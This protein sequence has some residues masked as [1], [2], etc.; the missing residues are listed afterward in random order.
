MAV[1]VSEAAQGHSD[2][3]GDGDTDDF[4]LFVCDASAHRVTNTG[5]A[6]G[7]SSFA[8]SGPLVAIRVP[9]RFQGGTDLNGDGDVDDL[10]MHVYDTRTGV[11]RNLGLAATGF[12]IVMVG[13]RVVFPADESSQGVDFNGDGDTLDADT[14]VYDA[15]TGTLT[16]FGFDTELFP[17]ATADLVVVAVNESRSGN[18]DLNGDGDMLDDVLFAL[19]LA[20]GEVINVGYAVY[21]SSFRANG[22]IVAFAVSE[23]GQGGVD[24]NGDGDVGDVVLHVFDATTGTVTNAALDCGGADFAFGDH[25]FAWTV[26]E[27]WQGNADLNGD[28]DVSDNVVHVFDTVM[29]TITNL[30]VAN[31][32]FG[33]AASGDWLAFAVNEGEQGGADLN[34]DGDAIDGV[35]FIYDHLTGLATNLGIALR[36]R[37]LL[38]SFGISGSLVAFRVSETG[39][40]NHDLNGDGDTGDRV[41]HVYDAAS[42]TLTN[43][44]VAGLHE[45]LMGA[46]V[47]AFEVSEVRQG[48]HDLNRN[49]RADDPSVLFVATQTHDAPCSAGTVNSSAGPPTAVLRVNGM[50]DSAVS[51]PGSPIQVSFSTSPAGPASAR[52]ALW[53][54]RGGYRLNIGLIIGSDHLGC[55][56]NPSPLQPGLFPQPA[57]CMSGGL[58]LGRTCGDAR[59]LASPQRAP[60][61]ITVAHGIPVSGVFSLQGIVQDNGSTTAL[62]FSVTNA[63]Q[64]IIQ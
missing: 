45:P 4:V 35:I 58:P 50:Q 1:L 53:A 2:L 61:V 32:Q 6:G 26:C 21:E 23:S 31:S 55:M 7:L 49:G 10:V 39:Q 16:H 41:A 52:Y 40:G 48:M 27:R 8:M 5:L 9:E 19:R 20:T 38:A 3:N 57:W 54:W 36:S 29:G 18:A 64:L 43:L 28:G 56:V 60:W 42:G 25:S 14:F 30:G 44:R 51:S 37:E 47:L 34:S 33:L 12:D 63:V 59:R 15:A 17:R 24:L 13:E 11:A 62:N 46:G 22:P